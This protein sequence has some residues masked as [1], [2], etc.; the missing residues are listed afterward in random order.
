VSTAEQLRLAV[1][2]SGRGSNLQ[3]FID[4]CERGELESRISLVIS[5][6][7]QAEGLQRAARAGIATRCINHRDYAT[8]EAFD[9]ALVTALQAESIDLVILAGFMRILTP[10]LIEPYLGRLLNIHPSLL[11]KYPGLNTHQ[12]ALD[13]GD[14]VAGATVHFVTPELDGG[15]PILQASEI[16]L[17]GDTAE[18]LST[19]IARLEHQIYPAVVRWFE[20]RRLQLSG[21]RALLD[22]KEIPTSGIQYTAELR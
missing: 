2:I 21:T 11:P 22:G 18:T 9:A 5:N 4:A 12:R 6:N 1:L 15:P 3:A 10:V 8:R 20:Q 14:R 13:A 7:P 19:R 17:Q 16:I